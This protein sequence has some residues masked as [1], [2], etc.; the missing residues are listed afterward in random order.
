LW[1]A[2][3]D[4]QELPAPGGD[5][6]REGDGFAQRVGP[7]DGERVGLRVVFLGEQRAGR[8]QHPPPGGQQRPERVDD[9]SLLAR[10][11]AQVV[12]APQPLAVG[13][14]THDARR[15]AGHVGDDS[16]EGT[17]IP[18]VV[19]PR[20][21]AGFHGDAIPGE[22][23]AL[24]VAAQARQPRLVAVARE[25]LDLGNF[26]QVS[27]LAPGAAQASSTRCPAAACSSGAASWAPRS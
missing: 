6:R 19:G 27:R 2:P 4:E 18:P 25:Q 17:A 20:R 14:A 21:V 23:Q 16:I 11:I 22:S 7:A 24:Q 10:E 26:E 3:G 9:A 1:P 13:M 15:G 5:F 8:V 12:L